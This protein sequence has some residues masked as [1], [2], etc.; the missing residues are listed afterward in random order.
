MRDLGVMG[1]L[2]YVWQVIQTEDF[3]Q[4]LL[5]ESL[6]GSHNCGALGSFLALGW[7]EENELLNL[8]QLIQ[9]LFHGESGPSRLRLFVN[10][11]EQRDPEHAIE[12]MNTDLAVG[13][14]IHGP[15]PEPVPV[16]QTAENLLDLL[17]TGVSVD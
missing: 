7:V 9:H 8:P 16:F 3:G 13:P 2:T 5:G 4:Y 6:L 10:V 12:G 11:L 14:V 15:P 17:L 1:C